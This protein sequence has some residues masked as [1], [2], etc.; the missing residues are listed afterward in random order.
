MFCFHEVSKN[1][2]D[3][4]EVA[5]AFRF[6]PFQDARIKA[7]AHRHLWSDVTQAHHF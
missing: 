6:Q 7:Y 5:F 4:R 2:I 3:T 1:V